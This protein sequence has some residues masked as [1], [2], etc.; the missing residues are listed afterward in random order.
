M[1][2]KIDYLSFT[3]QTGSFATVPPTR[4]MVAVREW[5]ETNASPLIGLLIEPHNFKALPGR[6]PYAQH[7]QRE[8]GGLSIF[9][10]TE[11]EE[12]LFEIGGVGCDILDRAEIL[13]P[14]I[15]LVHERLTRIDIT[16][17]ILTD[18]T[19]PDFAKQ[20][21]NKRHKSG[22]EKHSPS[23]Y[24]VYIGSKTS[25]RFAKVYRYNE[26]HPR[27]KL[28]RVEH[29]L[30]RKE[31]RQAA[32]LMLS[33]GLA[34]VVEMCGRTFGWKH[35]DWQPDPLSWGKLPTIEK[36]H[37]TKSTIFWLNSQVLPALVKAQ[38]T[39][40]LDVVAWLE[41]Y[42]LPQVFPDRKISLT[43]I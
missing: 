6:A 4:L 25:E 13:M 31:A 39:G 22:G 19:P 37:G 21:S 28:L 43:E 18:T 7:W 9:A 38:Q 20:R 17:D 15:G 14:L 27:A 24:T 1:F 41:T 26:P 35:P 11:R 36:E 40:K 33:N 16:A 5:I 29:T 30:K 42:V 3:I 2:Y 23:G 8:D 34:Y 10:G 32:K 12:I